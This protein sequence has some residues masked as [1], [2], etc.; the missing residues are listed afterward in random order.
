[1]TNGWMVDWD[2]VTHWS[3]LAQGVLSFLTF[4]ATGICVYFTYHIMKWAI[5]Q[6]RSGIELTRLSIE[7]IQRRRARVDGDV[8]QFL[9]VAL[10]QMEILL[11]MLKHSATRDLPAQLNGLKRTVDDIESRWQEI[12]GWD[13][14]SSLRDSMLAPML[15][16]G[17]L[18]MVLTTVAGNTGESLEDHRAAIFKLIRTTVEA[19]ERSLKDEY[20]MGLGDGILK[21]DRPANPGAALDVR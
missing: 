6:S 4:V 20:G 19:W 11:L 3:V 15:G 10:A 16:V 21:Y 5:D 2:A 14:G 13:I 18:K 8:L 1:M 17:S 7:D 9:V 12:L